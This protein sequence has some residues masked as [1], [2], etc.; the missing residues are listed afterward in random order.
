MRFSDTTV[1]YFSLHHHACGCEAAG[2]L[3]P[4][5]SR[6]EKD[7]EEAFMMAF[8]HFGF[9]TAFWDGK[10]HCPVLFWQ[11]VGKLG[12]TWDF[13]GHEYGFT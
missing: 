7:K 3:R 9:S 8:L 10:D 4:R 5:L 12:Y 11:W 2:A 1:E 6:H 13:L